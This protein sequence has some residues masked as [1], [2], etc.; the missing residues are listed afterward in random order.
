MDAHAPLCQ[1]Q[2]SNCIKYSKTSRRK[3]IFA[4]RSTLESWG[5]VAC[6]GLRRIYRRLQNVEMKRRSI[7]IKLLVLQLAQSASEY[8][9]KYA[10][11]YGISCHDYVEEG[12]ILS[13]E[14]RKW[15]HKRL[16]LDGLL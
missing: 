11:I 14:M 16:W 9:G 4:R 10:F 13:N 6:Y 3:K 5:V 15:S 2:S 1:F 8:F 7:T 12:H